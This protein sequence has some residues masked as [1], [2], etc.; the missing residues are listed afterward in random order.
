MILCLGG[1][2][3]MQHLTKEQIEELR[4]LLLQKKKETLERIENFL[5]DSSLKVSS[6]VGDEIDVADREMERQR[7]ISLREKE[8]EYLKQIEY[9]LRKI[10][11]GTYGI[12]ERCGEPISYER[13]KA[14][15]I[16]IYCIKCKKKL[17]EE[18]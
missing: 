8:S 16:S 15:P 10:E 14:R 11:E 4:K 13:L 3:I 18:D 2:V 7:Q 6:N 9:A 5:K 12:C 1:F 17:E